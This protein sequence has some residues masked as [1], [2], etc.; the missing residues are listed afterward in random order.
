MSRSADEQRNE[1]L[2][3]ARLRAID[4]AL[5]AGRHTLA[6]RRSICDAATE[7][8]IDRLLVQAGV[9]VVPKTGSDALSPRG[10]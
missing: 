3:A 9:I 8:D 10:G 1:L 2:Y 6:L 7:E 5:N 4:A